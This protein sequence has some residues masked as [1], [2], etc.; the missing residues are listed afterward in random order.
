MVHD[1]MVK[2]SD[3]GYLLPL[4]TNPAL[5][6]CVTISV[7]RD[8]L[9]QA[10][11]WG[12]LWRLTRWYHWAESADKRA[13]DVAAVWKRIYSNARE[14]LDCALAFQGGFQQEDCNLKFRPDTA[15]PYVTIYDPSSCYNRFLVKA[16]TFLQNTITVYGLPALTIKELGFNTGSGALNLENGRLNISQYSS[17]DLVRSAHSLSPISIAVQVGSSAPLMTTYAKNTGAMIVALNGHGI[18][19]AADYVTNLPALTTS[20]YGGSIAMLKGSINPAQPNGLYFCPSY[21]PQTWVRVNDAVSGGGGGG[22]NGTIITDAVGISLASISAAYAQLND[23]PTVVGTKRLTIG[24]PRGTDGNNGTSGTIITDAV[25]ISLASIS[26]AYAQL[27]DH[28]TVVGT[29][30]LTVGIPRGE[31][32]AIGAQGVQGFTLDDAYPALGLTKTYSQLISA[33]GSCLPFV[34]GKFDDFRLLSVKGRWS[35]FNATTLTK[36]FTSGYGVADY[37]FDSLP[38]GQVNANYY[39]QAPLESGL[40]LTDQ[41]NPFQVEST[42]APRQIWLYFNAAPDAPVFGEVYATYQVYHRN[43]TAFVTEAFTVI[44]DNRIVSTAQSTFV[45]Q[46]YRIVVSGQYLAGTVDNVNYDGD[47]CYDA[48]RP[49]SAANNYLTRRLGNRGFLVNAA[50]APDPLPGLNQNA[51]CPGGYDPDNVYIFSLVG[52][53][54]PFTFGTFGYDRGPGGSMTVTVTQL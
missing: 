41:F 42:D 44:C 1:R 3:K 12:N 11:F 45:G 5:S 30:R 54:V 16:P 50:Y 34:V 27:N 49:L 10:A 43:P 9:H 29:K 28:P 52:T 39:Q 4:V 15:A 47:C 31:T 21:S 22:T 19:Q 32:G 17:D 26:A 48:A 7:P 37:T 23:H 40:P 25:G 46:S 53:G 14:N 38:F 18:I 8:T 6:D 33:E 2:Q 51:Y 36:L 13:I 24:V 35:G 20:E